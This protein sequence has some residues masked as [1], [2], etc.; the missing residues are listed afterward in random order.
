MDVESTGFD[1]ERSEIIEV[2][3]AVFNRTGIL[4]TFHSLVRPKKS[5]PL[6]IQ[7]LTGLGDEHLRDS[8]RIG[9]LIPQIREIIGSRPVVGHWVRFD[10]SMLQNAGVSLPNRQIDTFQLATALLPDLPNY[11]L[12]T[13]AEALGVQFSE[14][15]HHRATA[16]LHTAIGIFQKLLDRI[17]RFDTR[18]L[19]DV[20]RYA[21]QAGWP[22]ADLFATAADSDLP[23]PLFGD[24][25]K[26][27]YRFP[28]LELAFLDK[29][30]KPE[31]L[32]KTGIQQPIDVDA[33]K[34]FLSSEGPLSHILTDYES[35][36][37]QIQMAQAVAAAF[38][39]DESLM[40]EAGTGT[41]KSL[42]YLL[43][44]ALYALTRGERVV[45]ST[46]TL[47]LQDQLYRKDLPDVRTTLNAAGFTEPLRV[48]V[49]KGRDNYLCLSRW[50]QHSL[51]PIED[52]ADASLRAKILLWLGGTQTGDKSELRLT[53]EENTHWR[54]FASERGRCSIKRCNHARNG[55]C[56]YYRARANAAN[57]HVIIANHAL[58]LTNV[59]GGGFVMPGY[60]R[61][62][63]DEAH[64]LEDEATDQFGFSLT[65]EAIDEVVAQLVRTDPGSP[66][67]SLPIAVNFLS[68]LAEP[69]A[70]ENAPQAMTL[71]GDAINASETARRHAAELYR[72]LVRLLPPPRTRGGGYAEQLRITEQVRIQGTWMEC[73]VV[74][75]QLDH[76]LRKMLDIGRWFLQ[77]LDDLPLPDD[78]EDPDT[79]QR[80][81]LVLDLG[82][83]LEGLQIAVHQMMS[84][85]EPEQQ[86]HVHW[87]SRSAM[88]QIVSLNGA[89]LDVSDMLR[90]LVFSR[91]RSSI[92]TSATMTIDGSFDYMAE[93]LGAESARRLA[94]GS[95]FDHEGST[96]VYVADDINEPNHPNYTKTMNNSLIELLIAS[97]GRAL[98]LFTNYRALR[99]TRSAIK[100]PLEEHNIVVLAQGS[101]GSPRQLIDRLRGSPGTVI[102]GTASFWEGVDIVGD[103]LS[104]VVITKL[105]FPVPSDPV[106]EAR[107]ELF[108][109]PFME[110][111]LPTAVLKFKQGF[112]RLIRSSRDV[113]ACVVYDRRVVSKRYG[114][115]FIQSLPPCRVTVGST[116]D[117]PEAVG[118]WL[119][120]SGGRPSNRLTEGTRV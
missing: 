113:G 37:T 51:E 112:G 88:H 63:I 114:S 100:Q 53:P 89:P 119:E 120:R 69:A 110:L 13:V 36:P 91:M 102:L 54:K 73:L 77:V 42:A 23:Y 116:Y 111:S 76:A 17:D 39:D 3:I 46:D 67:G 28:P 49:M 31:A 72:Q 35:R 64:H 50:F 41:G 9:E 4:D 24:G 58:V 5:V 118:T 99:E 30:E 27:G 47:A 8:P 108:D 15:A 57:A 45:V 62:I 85:F 40:V 7:Q 10:V 43:P 16:D 94:L 90:D 86:T 18:T 87:I 32:R 61:L 83:H 2:A 70:M 20:A 55:Q 78:R 75:E 14:E 98:V 12:G 11:S 117:L 74:W 101:D 97:K 56:F 1:P 48:S 19:G 60:D 71:L 80:D 106:F 6:E 81:D 44:A 29:R 93:R 115:T 96:L 52:P 33:I 22:E 84:I 107:C 68:R 82:Q 38:N 95:P 65:R 21:R 105:P 25:Q 104:V 103:A 79:T 59:E 26:D 109:E 92:L 34:E 66:M